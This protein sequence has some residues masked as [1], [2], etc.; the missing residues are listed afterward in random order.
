MKYRKLISFVVVFAMMLNVSCVTGMAANLKLKNV[1]GK[2]VK[3][4][5]S[6]AFQVDK[7]SGIYKNATVVKVTAKKGN[8]VYYSTTGKFIKGNKI[9]SGKSKKIT[10]KATGSLY[11]FSA[12]KVLLARYTYTIVKPVITPVKTIAPVVT[13]TPVAQ[14]DHSLDKYVAPVPITASVPEVD[15]TYAQEDALISCQNTVASVS[16]S[17]TTG[18]TIVQGSTMIVKITAGGTYHIKGALDSGKVVVDVADAVVHLVFDGV[19]FNCAE[20]AV[21]TFSKAS[22]V[23]LT[24]VGDNHLTDKAAAGVSVEPTIGEGT[25]VAKRQFLLL[26]MELLAIVRIVWSLLPHVTKE[27][28][29]RIP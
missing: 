14:V 19:T 9:K 4:V 26:S 20:D 1:S 17:N 22:L 28:C 3:V 24:L 8:Q 25:L 2:E 23:K 6:K 10:F 15:A 21:V 27:S 16:G 12:K 18:V 29:A 13:S 5:K 7:T 11:I